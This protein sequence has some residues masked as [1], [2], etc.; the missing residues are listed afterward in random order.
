MSFIRSIERIR[1]IIPGMSAAAIIIEPP[2]VLHG[3]H[4]AQAW[5]IRHF[6]Y[7]RSW[8]KEHR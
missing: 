1:L 3:R 4:Y 7:R 2:D 8:Y 5:G 6:V